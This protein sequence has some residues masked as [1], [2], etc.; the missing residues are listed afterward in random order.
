M[1]PEPT[2]QFT[3]PS[4][5]DDI[6]LDCRVYN[7]PHSVLNSGE[8]TWNP[9]GAIIAHPYAPLGGSYD[10]GVVLSAAAEF[11]KL[12]FV[13]G[14]FNFRQDPTI[15]S[16][17]S[18]GLIGLLA[19][20]LAARKVEPAGRLSLSLKITSHSLASLCTRLRDSGL[21]DLLHI[22]TEIPIR[23]CPQFH[24]P[25]RLRPTPLLREARE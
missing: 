7:P 10:D 3:I 15:S 2:F 16:L 6:A 20:V 12:D 22:H 14:T 18:H 5:H 24:R 9:Q 8:A 13:V 23:F 21:L 17:R 25:V 19:V 11:L 4:I 1:L